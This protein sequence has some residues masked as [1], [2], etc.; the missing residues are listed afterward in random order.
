MKDLSKALVS[1]YPGTQWSLT[2]NEYDGL[3][4]MST[5][6]PKPSREELE[7][8]CDRLHQIW[9][10]E[11]YKRDRAK[12]YP[13][14]ADQLDMQYW[15]KINGTTKWADAIQAVKDKYPKG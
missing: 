1:L 3:N 12:E 14:I 4:W 11:Q 2:G 13:S 5:D 10:S 6:V 8:E 7:A 9:V 15:D